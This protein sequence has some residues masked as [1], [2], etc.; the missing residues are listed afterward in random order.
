MKR[1]F[2]S[3]LIVV[4]IL[5]AAYYALLSI[6]PPAASEVRGPVYST[7]EVMRG[8]LSV[9]VEG[10]GNLNPIYLSDL[11]TATG[12]YVES[13]HIERGQ[14]V[15]AGQ[16]VAVL[17]NDE[18]GYE[19]SQLELELQRKKMDL[20]EMLGVSPDMV[21]EAN[22][23]RSL[24]VVA[25]ISG[26]VTNLSVKDG[27]TV[28]DGQILATIVN[29]SK[30]VMVAEL[31]TSEVASLEVGDKVSL[32]Q[33]DY[34][35]QSS[36]EGV[37]VDIDPTAIPKDTHFVYRTTIHID[38][39]GLLKPG[40]EYYLTLKTKEKDIWV[41]RLQTIDSFIEETIVRANGRGTVTSLHVRDMQHV[42]KGDLIVS[43]GGSDTKRY[44]EQ[45]QLD[46]RD[47]ELQIAQKE[48]I[49]DNLEIRSPIAGT[50]SWIWV[51]PGVRL[52][53]GESIAGIFDNS[54]MNLHV[55]VDE[56]DVVH[57]SEGQEG[58]VL[59][60]AMPGKSWPARVINVD[61]MG[62][63]QDGI[64]QYG[65]TIEVDGT[66]ELKPGMTATVRIFIEEKENVLL[67]PIEAVFVQDGQAVVEVLT[68]DGPR[69]VPV[70]LGL[71]SDRYAEVVSGLEEGQLVIT[72]SN[73]DRLDSKLLEAQEVDKEI[74]LPSR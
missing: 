13:V 34:L 73:A 33:K 66:E 68:S 36:V 72:G 27:N 29:D 35:Y 15:E 47:L 41:S 69:I 61:M 5:G 3:L 65:V 46:I 12:G 26:R 18:V 30:L 54:R 74:P 31:L 51:R 37:V 48:H 39:P 28:T 59:V 70:K 11:T 17:R 21:L 55:T 71:I 22:P 45:A 50:V 4:I 43:L 64:A 40:Q 6:L 7:A 20:A 52:S 42:K 44:I 1:I 2:G 53:G 49:R 58:V 32:H 8:D 56:I 23:N 16:L 60:E 14:K 9:T 19:L 63:A 10:F 62:R 57:L 67:I 38:N 24:D 25:P